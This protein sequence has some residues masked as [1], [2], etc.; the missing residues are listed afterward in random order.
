[1]IDRSVLMFETADIAGLGQFTH[2]KSQR[3]K[4]H[5]FV[6]YHIICIQGL[7]AENRCL[8]QHHAA[9]VLKVFLNQYEEGHSFS[10]VQK[11]MVVGQSEVHHL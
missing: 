2:Q 4:K 10:A 6:E 9:R 3:W 7:E 11:S 1:M 8:G 5:G